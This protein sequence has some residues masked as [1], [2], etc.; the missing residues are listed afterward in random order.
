M[1]P[2][3]AAALRDRLHQ[4]R[5]DALA[6]LAAALPILDTGL[7]RVIADTNAVLAAIE[8]EAGDNSETA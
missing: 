3:T 1:K 2:D 7:M 4:L 8:A 5:A 6:Q